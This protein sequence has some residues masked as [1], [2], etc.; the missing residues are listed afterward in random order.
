[1]RTFGIVRTN[2]SLS[3]FS[4]S[5]GG[6]RSLT[7]LLDGTDREKGDDLDANLNSGPRVRVPVVDDNYWNSLAITLTTGEA[8]FLHQHITASVPG[9]LLGQ[10]L[11]EK[12]AVTQ[13]LKLPRTA[14][15]SDFADLPFVRTR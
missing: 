13:I 14:S 8:E 9:S 15:F 12:D 5:K 4:R 3:E 7:S 1:M 6:R 10:I 11:L 2:L